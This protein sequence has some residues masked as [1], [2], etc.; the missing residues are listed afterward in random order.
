MSSDKMKHRAKINAKGLDTT[1]VTEDHARHLAVSHEK[2]KPIHS[3]FIVEGKTAKVEIDDEGNR[4]LKINLTQ[5]EPVPAAQ[6]D[7]VREFMRALWRQRPEQQGQ[8]VLDGTA[9]TGSSV[10][11]T[12]A[13]LG[14]QIERDA[15][16]KPIGIWDGD[17][18]APL[19]PDG[20]EP[21]TNPRPVPEAEDD[22]QEGGME[23]NTEEPEQT[24]DA[25][26]PVVAFSGR[27]RR[28]G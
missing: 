26:S 18:D 28:R 8:A 20:D 17:P 19:D 15:D 9:G 7:T 3:L 13:A 12:E 16:G 4:L 14:A 10:E 21:S 25:S 6:E 22:A 11:D 23:A 1:G 27:G 24:G 5:V 2:G